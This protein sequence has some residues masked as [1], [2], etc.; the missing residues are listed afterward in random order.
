[1]PNGG[2]GG[3]SPIFIDTIIVQDGSDFAA[4]LGSMIQNQ[5]R[6]ALSMRGGAG[7]AGT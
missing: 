5:N 4:V 2:G 7:Y 3:D 1:M 6:N